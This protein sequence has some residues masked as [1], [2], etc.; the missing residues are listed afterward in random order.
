[1]GAQNNSA[2]FDLNLYLLE[3]FSLNTTPKK[4]PILVLFP[5]FCSLL[6][7]ALAPF[8]VVPMPQFNF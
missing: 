8:F 4:G 6:V 2:L 5:Q 7:L 1:M 3:V